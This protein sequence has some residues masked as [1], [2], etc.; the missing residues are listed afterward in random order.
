MSLWRHVALRRDVL[1]L[2]LFDLRTNG[3]FICYKHDSRSNCETTPRLKEK[4]VTVKSGLEC[5]DGRP[6]ECLLVA[7]L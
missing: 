3:N 6:R 4:Y 5:A 1:L 7:L 2:N